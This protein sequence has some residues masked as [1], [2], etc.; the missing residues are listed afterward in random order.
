MSIIRSPRFFRPGQ[1][2]HDTSGVGP[3]P[4]FFLLLI[5]LHVR[6]IGRWIKRQNMTGRHCDGRPLTVALLW[7]ENPIWQREV[8]YEMFWTCTGRLGGKLRS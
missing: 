2:P 4:R 6:L 3:K 5:A 1:E 7:P 8:I